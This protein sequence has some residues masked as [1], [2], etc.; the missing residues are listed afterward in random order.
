MLPAISHVHAETARH[1]SLPEHGQHCLQKGAETRILIFCCNLQRVK[2]L[3][4]GD[5]HHAELA[6]LEEAVGCCRGRAAI[7]AG[8]TALLGSLLEAV[9]RT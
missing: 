5:A 3:K 2:H 4:S 6:L 9:S 1:Q 7:L 8:G